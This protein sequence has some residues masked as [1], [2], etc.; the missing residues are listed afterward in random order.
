MQDKPST[1]PSPFTSE[2]FPI[3]KIAPLDW[4]GVG[5]FNIDTQNDAKIRI[6]R[7]IFQGP[8][9]LGNLC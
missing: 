8:S 2:I 7:Y 4:F 9:F 1:T 3:E 6:R 5:K